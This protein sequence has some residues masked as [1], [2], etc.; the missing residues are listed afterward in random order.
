[1]NTKL[2]TLNGQPT[3]L[4]LLFF[5]RMWE[6]FS[7][8]GMRILLVLYMIEELRLGDSQAYGV[9][10]LYCGLL[11]FGGIAG[12]WIADRYFGLRKTIAIGAWIILS[13]HIC[14]SLG[15]LIPG[16]YL[17]L[18]LI[19]VGSSLFSSNITALL[20]LFYEENDS[21]R[22]QGF[23]FF[24]MGINLGSFL[25]TLGCGYI[26]QQWGWEPA[27][28]LA[29]LGMLMGII[30]LYA[31]GYILE[32]KGEL[33]TQPV[34]MKSL[35]IYLGIALSVPLMSGVISHEEW[36]MSIVPF[37]CI[38]TVL[39]VFYKMYTSGV[40]TAE[41]VLKMM[42][43][44]SALVLF[45]GAEE[46][47]GSSLIVFTDRF[48]VGT[49]AGMEIP[50]STVVGL[51]P[52]TIILGGFLVAAISKYVSSYRIFIALAGAGIAFMMLSL[53][54]VTGQASILVVVNS[55]IMISMA[56]LFIGPAVYAFFSENIPN[57][58][59]GVVMSIIPLGFSSAS[60]LGGFFSKSMA[61]EEN[62]VAQP[63]AQF[64]E[65]YG[66]LALVL[67]AGVIVIQLALM[68]LNSKQTK[69]C[70]T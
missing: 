69:E 12:G 38:G 19:V 43:Y 62:T 44:F 18:A 37:V 53:Q 17:G 10:A 65:G 14:L 7:Y 57:A 36:F 3:A 31:F 27:F 26:S 24:Y 15:D 59:R 50:S 4:Y 25:A 55:V 21:R 16:F 68:G 28:G 13:G 22:D 52:L 41:H 39:C 6:C 33:K 61:L 8:Y 32:N 47:I 29:A 70:V 66:N 9:Y 48:A 67:F 5:I 60:L 51:N 34:R 30:L 58:W 56:E 11:E 45:Y 63:M 1:M 42:I 35:S 40:F 2:S 46:Q 64:L 49:I 23:T 20:G 54:K